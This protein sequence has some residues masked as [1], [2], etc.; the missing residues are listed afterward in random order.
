MCIRA[1]RQHVSLPGYLDHAGLLAAYRRATV[2]TLPSWV[3]SSPVAL[4]QAM[5]AGVP[6]V[7]T[8]IGGTDHLIADG[9]SGLRVPLRD[10]DALAAALLRVLQDPAASARYAAAARQTA[11][12]RFTQAAAAAKSAALYRMMN[13]ERKVHSTKYKA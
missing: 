12:A 8:A 13:A 4:A 1:R 3:E 7:T 11:V 2:F 5:A 10:P 6:V 9:R